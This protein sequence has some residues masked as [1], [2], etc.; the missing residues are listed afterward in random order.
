VPWG[1]G[2]AF[3]VYNNGAGQVTIAKA[4]SGNMTF[5][6]A[7]STSE[8]PDFKLAEGGFATFVRVAENTWICSG[9]GVS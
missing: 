9:A 3:V 1:N 6:F 8:E 2:S 5:R 4:D 7:G